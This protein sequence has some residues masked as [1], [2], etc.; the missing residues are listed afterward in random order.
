MSCLVEIVLVAIIAGVP[1]FED[2]QEL[3]GLGLEKDEQAIT[4]RHLFNPIDKFGLG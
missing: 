2:F 3:D 1:I 4:L